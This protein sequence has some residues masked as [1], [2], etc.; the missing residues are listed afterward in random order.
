ME[1]LLS[2]DSASS[3]RDFDAIVGP[4]IDPG[5]RLAVAMVRDPDEA[6]DAVQEAALK[7]WRSL[8]QLRDP[9]RARSWF[10][11]IVANQC[12]STM[13]R[14]WWRVVRLESRGQWRNDPGES[15][16]RTVDLDRAVNRLNPDDRAVLHLHY[17]L[18]LPLE[19]VGRVLGISAGA[20]KS[21]VYRAVDRL[22]PELA[23]E[24][25]S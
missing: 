9:E 8:S 3:S 5:Y 17:F 19:E 20:A 7:A 12:R 25:Q 13:R 16:V 2:N 22:R 10:L 1:V 21:R 24:E 4:W 11:A 23:E 14:P 6:Y 18:D 15:A